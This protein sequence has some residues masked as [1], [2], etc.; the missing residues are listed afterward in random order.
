ML[1]TQFIFR[2]A[3]LEDGRGDRTCLSRE[4]LIERRAQGIDVQRR[5]ERPA[6]RLVGLLDGRIAR[7]PQSD[8]GTGLRF[9]AVS[10]LLGQ[11][12]I[13]DDGPAILLHDD[14]LRFQV[15][16]HHLP[17]V[18]ERNRLSDLPDQIQGLRLRHAHA[19]HLRMKRTARQILHRIVIGPVRLEGLQDM[20]DPG[21][22]DLGQVLGFALESLGVFV[23][24]SIHRP[25]G[26][27]TVPAPG[28]QFLGEE[29]F[30]GDLDLYPAQ[31]PV[32]QGRSAICD[33]E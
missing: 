6:G 30:Q 1:R 28:V 18:H 9:A 32:H 5:L 19:I 15:Q 25:G 31:F 14:V 33:A 21:M 4:H 16:M 17:F 11:A 8:G 22:V 2:E 20:H 24:D 13:D 7:R 10:V 29:L 26:D 27:R 3:V 12:E 23:G